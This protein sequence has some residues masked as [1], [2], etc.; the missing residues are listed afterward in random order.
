[1][2]KK[3]VNVYSLSGGSLGWIRNSRRVKNL[4][5]ADILVLEGGADI[6]P[7]IYG[8]EPNSTVNWLSPERD[9]REIDVLNKS[10][11]SGKLIVGI[12]RGAQLQTAVNGGVLVQHINHPG[13]HNIRLYDGQV[14]ETNSL[15]HQ[16]CN[17]YSL[18]KSDYKVLGWSLGLSDT[19]LGEGDKDVEFPE[20]AFD[21][22]DRVM[23][24]EIIYFP[25]TRCFGVQFHPEMMREGTPI[26]NKV[27]DMI[28]ELLLTNTIAV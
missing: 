16:L 17:P 23:E 8:Q 24:P 9:A 11:E 10:I 28:E 1:M 6:D 5:E 21:E 15:H 25:K 7:K 18:P 4:Y 13:R 27:N 14:L 22:N 26:Q 19:Y 20:H 12:C 3:K 2:N